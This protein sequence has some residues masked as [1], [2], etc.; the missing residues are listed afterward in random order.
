MVTECVKEPS[1][2]QERIDDVIR[3][4]RNE[5]GLIGVR[6]FMRGRDDITNEFIARDVLALNDG[7]LAGNADE[8]TGKDI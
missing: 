7:V 5:K 6:I 3:H 8:I 2:Y 1:Y 4:E